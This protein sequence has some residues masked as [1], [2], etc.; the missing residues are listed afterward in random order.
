MVS[1]DRLQKVRLEGRSS[2]SPV[3]QALT[4][5][6][7]YAKQPVLL[8]RLFFPMLHTGNMPQ[9]NSCGM[10]GNI[11]YHTVIPRPTLQNTS[12]TV[13]EFSW[14]QSF[15]DGSSGYPLQSYR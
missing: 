11:K 3:L 13:S 2:G 4:F 8:D 6:Q 12:L 9:E 10:L 7:A 5:Y 1:N 14:H 15:F